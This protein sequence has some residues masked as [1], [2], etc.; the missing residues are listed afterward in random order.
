MSALLMPNE[1]PQETGTRT[2]TCEAFVIEADH[3]RLLVGE[4]LVLSQSRCV[5]YLLDLYN[6]TDEP[7][8]RAVLSGFLAEIGGVSAVEGRRMHEAL[9]LAVAAIDVESAYVGMVLR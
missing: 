5:D 6:L 1:V 8:V 2:L 3:V 4:Q 7:A 9:D